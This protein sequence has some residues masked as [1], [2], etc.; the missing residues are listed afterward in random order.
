MRILVV[1][2]D[3]E[4]RNFMKV[5][6]SPLGYEVLTASNGGEALDMLH[7]QEIELVISDLVMEPIDGL[8]LC[9]RIR[10][11]DFPHYLYIIILTAR[12]TSQDLVQLLEEGADDFIAKP[13]D[14]EELRVRIMAGER[15]VKLERSYAEKNRSLHEA[16]ERLNEA[17]MIIRRD[18]EAAARL[19]QS[20]LPASSSS[21]GGLHFEWL[22][23][24]SRILGG[25][26]FNYFLLEDHRVGF[27]IIDVAGHGIPSAMLSFT[28]SNTLSPSLGAAGFVVKPAKGLPA[29][30]AAAPS[31]VVGELNRHFVGDEESLIYFTMIYGLFDRARE[32]LTIS[33]A[34]HPSPFLVKPAGASFFIGSGGYPVGMLSFA[35]YDEHRVPMQKGDRLFL[36]SDG[37][38]DCMNA[39]KERFSRERF[40][41]YLVQSRKKSLRECIEG[42]EAL[43]REWA[44]NKDFDDDVSLLAFEME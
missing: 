6:L 2:D 23:M 1:D 11:I 29:L 13:F 28:L 8:E 20:L 26:I 42:M 38:I 36:Y 22:F 10:K 43:L 15:I 27:Y 35:E 37:V 25:D 21:M 16:H 41:E 18:L 34:G 19:Q 39:S 14:N 30:Q 32:T 9:R 44:G 24:P 5:F 3:Q 33:Q 7:C 12:E 17:Y 4:L 31:A 40:A